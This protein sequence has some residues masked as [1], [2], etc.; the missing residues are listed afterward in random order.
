MSGREWALESPDSS[1]RASLH[2]TRGCGPV[3]VARHGAAASAEKTRRQCRRSAA[4]ALVLA[5]VVW[6]APAASAQAIT[7]ASIA[8]TMHPNR[9]HAR[10]AVTLSV[11]YSGG[12]FGLPSPVRGLTLRFPAGLGLDIPRLSACNV[13]ELERIGPR[14]CPSRSVIGSGNMLFAARTG[15]AIVEEKV[16]LRAFLGPPNNLEPTIAIFA[17]GSKPIGEEDVVTGR[18]SPDHIPFGERILMHI[19][20]LPTLPQQ[21][22]ASL[23]SLSLTIGST[24]PHALAANAV[25][26]PGRCPRGGFPFASE[27]I[28]ADGTHD[29]VLTTSPCPR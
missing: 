16:T 5:L 27:S 4:P 8:A 28:Y 3:H 24:H 26:M 14:A 11:V 22:D 19:P 12:E 29:R 6:V 1:T 20:P 15:S 18:M 2:Q 17:E 7:S 9:P 13:T 21:P 23:L 10:G 25:V